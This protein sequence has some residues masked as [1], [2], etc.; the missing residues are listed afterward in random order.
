[1]SCKKISSSTFLRCMY[2]EKPLLLPSCQCAYT[3]K[4][5][6]RIALYSTLTVYVHLFHMLHFYSRVIKQTMPACMQNGFSPLNLAAE[7]GNLELVKSLVQLTG[8]EK[9]LTEAFSDL[10]YVSIHFLCKY[11]FLM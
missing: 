4:H 6:V 9:L 10:S 1:M 2:D 3:T 5:V 11:T 7:K 8:A